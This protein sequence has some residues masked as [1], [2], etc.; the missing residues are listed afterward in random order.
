[1]I[2]SETADELAYLTETC[3]EITGE[4][5]P[6][7]MRTDSRS[8]YDH[9]YRKG[10]CQ[11]KRLMVE[12]SVIREAVEEELITEVQWVET[13]VQLADALTKKMVPHVLL[14]A[15]ETSRLP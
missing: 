9:I 4:K 12:L 11:E 2:A 14:R 13:K 6:C 10:S 7:F 3:Q 5:V 8:L 1:M 15:L